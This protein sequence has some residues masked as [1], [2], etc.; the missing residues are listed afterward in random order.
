[1]KDSI[2]AATIKDIEN[3]R[4]VGF[5]KYG[6]TLDREDLSLK[7]WVQHAYEESLDKSLYLK[8]IITMLDTEETK[9]FNQ[10]R[11]EVSKKERELLDSPDFKKC[12]KCQDIKPLTE[13]KLNSCKFQRPAHKGRNVNCIDCN[14]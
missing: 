4:D 11:R 6:V 13:F 3:R 14:K 10:L 5:K 12:F 7:D 1:M 9:D 8:K 2:V